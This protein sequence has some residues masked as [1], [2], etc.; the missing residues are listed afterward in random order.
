MAG[1]FI[2]AEYMFNHG[3]MSEIPTFVVCSCLRGY[4]QR[5]WTWS[6]CDHNRQGWLSL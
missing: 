3:D 6:E 5:I 4:G 2:S 1:C